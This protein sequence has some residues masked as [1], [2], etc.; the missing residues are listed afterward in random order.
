[1]YNHLRENKAHMKIP[2]FPP[3]KYNDTRVR[4]AEQRM[5]QRT[6]LS[7]YFHKRNYFHLTKIKI[8][9]NDWTVCGNDSGANLDLLVY[10]LT[11][12]TYF[13]LREQARKTFANRNL[14]PTMNVVFVLGKSRVAVVN[15]AIEKENQIYGDIVQGDFI[16]SYFN[17]TFKSLMTWRWIE[18]NF[19]KAKYYMKLDS[20]VF[21]NSRKVI[22]FIRDEKL[23]N[24]SALFLTGNIFWNES[25]H[26]RN[27]SKWYV[28]YQDYSSTGQTDNYPPYAHGPFYFFSNGIPR[29]FYALSFTNQDLWLVYNNNSVCLLFFEF[30]HLIKFIFIQRRMFTTE[31]WLE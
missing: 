26:R 28:S 20:D 27:Q 15:E 7:R 8:I 10:V 14:F 19:K 31:F 18:H 11:V 1:V 21:L 24:S 9:T 25:P 13:D 23:S 16:D 2:K 30:V 12:P 17:L 29:V 4:E 6:N 3:P 5:S 22:E